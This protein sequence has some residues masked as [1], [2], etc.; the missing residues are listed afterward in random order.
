LW[1]HQSSKTAAGRASA[2]AAG[3]ERFREVCVSSAE[4]QTEPSSASPTRGEH[5]SKNKEEEHQ[6]FARA[7]SDGRT[8]DFPDAYNPPLEGDSDSGTIPEIEDGG[9]PLQSCAAH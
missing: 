3:D 8:M 2:P 6:L 1:V 5:P 7:P 4:S 9:T